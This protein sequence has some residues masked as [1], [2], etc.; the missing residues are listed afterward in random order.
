[1]KVLEAKNIDDALAECRKFRDDLKE[2]QFQ[3]IKAS[4]EKITPVLLVDCIDDFM[5]F[6]KDEG[7]AD[8]EKGYRTQREINRHERSLIAF[9][10]ALEKNGE[11]SKT[12][13]FN[14]ITKKMVG[15]FYT[16]LLETR[17]FKNKTYNHYRAY[18]LRFSNYIIKEYKLNCDNN[19]ATLKKRPVDE[20]PRGIRL[21]AFL[22]ILDHTKYE[23]SFY[24][25]K[26]EKNR[27][28]NFYH[29]WLKTAFILGLYTG[30]RREEVVSMKWNG[31]KQSE[32]GEL[33]HIEVE[34]YKKARAKRNLLDKHVKIIKRVPINEDL[35]EFLMELG[36]E[37]KKGLDE[38]ILAPESKASRTTMMDYVTMA[39]AAYYKALFPE[40]PLK[41]K[42][43]RKT[44][45]TTLF[46][47]RGE[48][49]IEDTDHEGMS[50]L[51]ESYIDQ[52][53]LMEMKRNQFKKFGKLFTQK[54]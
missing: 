14:Q 7:V 29:D 38:Y 39:F 3:K 16:Y 10:V 12:I 53:M 54:L 51:N 11:N 19:I 44:Y 15:Y 26:H 4:E 46:G 6:I 9:C 47:K 45:T 24:K 27:T 31:I 34:H 33:T 5:A 36:Y 50:I 2:L 22:K 21:G 41:F 42:H 28:R 49:V 13:Q 1:M 52:E 20:D 17:Q 18:L 32:S 43:L 37:Q 25:K 30:G 40:A 23:N 8:H 48:K 35:F